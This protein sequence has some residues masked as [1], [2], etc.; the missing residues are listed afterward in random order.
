VTIEA[1]TRRDFD[2][3]IDVVVIDDGSLAMRGVAEVM[4]HGRPSGFLGTFPG[5]SAVDLGDGSRG[6]VVVIVDPFAG[7]GTSWDAL[8]AV[9]PHVRILV[10][11]ASVDP[12]DVREAIQAGV[13]G[14]VCKNADVATLLAAVAAAGAGGLYLGN[15]LSQAL[16]GRRGAAGPVGPA[17]SAGRAPATTAAPDGLTPRERDV[18]S[19]VARGFTHK[20]IG[21]RL[22]LTK[23]T[24][25]TYVHRVRQKIG[26]AN[27]AGLTRAAVHL[28]LVGDDA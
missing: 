7:G 27:K 10:M 6:C 28:G 22:G 3:H 11:T 9:P 18:L 20:Q 4:R 8:A 26:S 13:R 21:T 15:G 1:T 19:L 16:V 5:L 24:V 17:A 14:Y 23:A 2:M 25:D 12:A